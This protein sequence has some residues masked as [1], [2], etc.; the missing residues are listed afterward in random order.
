MNPYTT[1]F[2]EPPTTVVEDREFDPGRYFVSYYEM[3]RDFAVGEITKHAHGE[4]RQPS[5]DELDDA[6]RIIIPA[7]VMIFADGVRLAVRVG[8]E[9]QSQP[10]MVVPK[11]GYWGFYDVVWAA[12]D[13]DARWMSGLTGGPLEGPW[14]L[15]HA[16]LEELIAH[17]GGIINPCPSP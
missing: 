16:D 9:T 3:F 12:D 14:L 17:H 6:T 7:P 13:G 5:E 15:P 8:R 2:E 10:R 4:G 1:A 11:C